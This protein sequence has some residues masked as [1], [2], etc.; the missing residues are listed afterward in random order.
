MESHTKICH[1]HIPISQSSCF[2]LKHRRNLFVLFFVHSFF[3]F[4]LYYWFSK[5]LC[6][7]FYTIQF[8]MYLIMNVFRRSIM[9]EKLVRTIFFGKI[10]FWVLWT[11][12][13][14]RRLICIH[15]SGNRN[16][17]IAASLPRLCTTPNITWIGNTVTLNE[18]ICHCMRAHKHS[19]TYE[20]TH[21]N[22]VIP[23]DCGGE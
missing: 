19:D 1:Y 13:A 8:K 3:N 18:G 2:I 9:L 17:N 22:Q 15:W 5:Y 21:L 16:E 10:R 4:W 6:T 20:S 11:K 7:I 12:S 23:T 14:Y